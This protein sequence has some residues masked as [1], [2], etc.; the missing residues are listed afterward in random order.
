MYRYVVFIY[1]DTCTC[2]Y[3]GVSI[4]TQVHRAERPTLLC[5]LCTD[6]LQKCLCHSAYS[7]TGNGHCSMN[8]FW[9]N[10][11]LQRSVDCTM[12]YVHTS[13]WGPAGAPF[14]IINL[15]DFTAPGIHRRAYLHYVFMLDC[16]KPALSGFNSKV[17]V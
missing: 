11:T 3:I 16:G 4:S 15:H 14:S 8:Y 2:L 1:L 10:A 12:Y 9:L 7:L 17:Y 5:V 6:L 13:W